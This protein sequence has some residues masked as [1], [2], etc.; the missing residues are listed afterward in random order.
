[1]DRFDGK[2]VGGPWD[3]QQLAHYSKSKKFYRPMMP[4]MTLDDPPIIPVEIGEYKLNDYQQW[5]WWPTD[6]GNA[7]DKLLGPPR[8]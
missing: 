7:M 1:M 6:E 8:S 3:G 5:H 4:A 2:C